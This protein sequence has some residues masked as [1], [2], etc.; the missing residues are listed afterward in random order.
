V[1]GAEHPDW[2][3]ADVVSA[4][5]TVEA[6]PY[7]ER[8]MQMRMTMTAEE[9]AREVRRIGGGASLMAALERAVG[10]RASIKVLY[11]HP[12]QRLI[13][14]EGKRI[15]GVVANTAAGARRFEAKQAVVLT[16]G[17]YEYDEEMKISYLRAYPMYFYG[18]P[19]NTGDGVRM[20]QAVGA[21]LWHM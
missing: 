13:Q 15:A 10:Q 18:S 5:G 4:Y 12:A 14:D 2:E 17:G 19:M 6:Y 3:G 16:C 21:D 8:T 1:I 20:A 11:E 9:L 7:G